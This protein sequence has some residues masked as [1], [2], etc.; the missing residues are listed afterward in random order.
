MSFK[1]PKEGRD[2]FKN[3]MIEGGGGSSDKL[4]MFDAYYYCLLIGFALNRIDTDKN[5]L[6]AEFQK[7][8]PEQYKESKDYINGLLIS[9]E[10]KRNNT[11]RDDTSFQKVMLDIINTNEASNLSAIG[12]ERMNEYAL[13]G[14]LEIKERSRF[15]PQSREEFLLS[16]FEIINSI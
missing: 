5:A 13:R 14:F 10:L 8:Y 7:S 6:G 15:V 12:F 16:Y 11:K 1:F 4:N 2:Y 3:I 9:A